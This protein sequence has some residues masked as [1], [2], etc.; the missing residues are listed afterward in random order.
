VYEDGDAVLQ[1]ML[2]VDLRHAG[3]MSEHPADVRVPQTFQRAV[4][5]A[6]LWPGR[7]VI[8][9]GLGLLLAV[10]RAGIP[11]RRGGRESVVIPTPGPRP[12][13]TDPASETDALQLEVTQR[14]PNKRARTGMTGGPAAGP[15]ETIFGLPAAAVIGALSAVVVFALLAAVWLAW[16]LW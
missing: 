2:G 12:G 7:Q 13:L 1:E 11:V 14:T 6:G 10:R 9:E 8:G 15:R 3:E 4:R 5:V 16:R